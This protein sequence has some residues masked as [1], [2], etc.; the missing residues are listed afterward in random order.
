MSKVRLKIYDNSYNVSG[1]FA[2]YTSEPQW[3]APGYYYPAAEVE[4]LVEAV[5]KFTRLWE[6]YD[7]TTVVGNW[8]LKGI[9]ELRAA[10]AALKAEP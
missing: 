1:K 4:R 6:Y 2:T 10:L 8:P 5:Q 3:V 7:E 9:S